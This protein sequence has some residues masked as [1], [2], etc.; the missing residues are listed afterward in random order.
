MNNRTP[1]ILVYSVAIAAFVPLLFL[2]VSN[3]VN[4]LCWDQ[5]DYYNMFFQHLNWWGIFDYQ[6]GHHRMGLGGLVI[7]AVNTLTHWNLSVLSMVTMVGI[8]QIAML[9]LWVARTLNGRVVFADACIFV[10]VL[11]LTQLEMLLANQEIAQVVVPSLL[12]L[13]YAIV[14]SAPVS[15][16]KVLSLSVLQ[17]VLLFSGYG[18]TFF[19]ATVALIVGS[20]LRPHRLMPYLPATFLFMTSA[21]SSGIYFYGL[22]LEMYTPYLRFD[23]MAMIQYV[24]NFGAMFSGV[25]GPMGNV[26]GAMFILALIF[27]CAKSAWRFFRREKNESIQFFLAACVLCYIC[28]SAIGRT[29]VASRYMT[30]TSIGFAAIYIAS[31]Q[32]RL[33]AL[34]VTGLAIHGSIVTWQS[35]STNGAILLAQRCQNFITCYKAS[36]DATA[37]N[38]SFAVYPDPTRTH[39]DNKLEFMRQNKLSFF[40]QT[41]NKL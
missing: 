7:W 35:Q 31:R 41:E 10:S 16:V 28:D 19:P 34:L 24:F 14:W 12:M 2:V 23:P 6:H 17:F 30:I 26:I 9:L 13:A 25:P 3:S 37:C 20:I 39:L 15:A 18:V 22:H 27:V 11:T 1:K 40:A 4:V 8:F 36:G 21:V 33:V 5:W 38:R 29:A 32:N